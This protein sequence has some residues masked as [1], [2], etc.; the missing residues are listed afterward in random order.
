MPDSPGSVDPGRVKTISGI[1][2]FA[3]VL[4]RNRTASAMSS[5]RIIAS[6]TTVSRAHSVIAVSTRPG[7]NAV[8]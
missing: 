7:Q 5:G 1:T 2:Q 3:D 4:S 8:T 6:C